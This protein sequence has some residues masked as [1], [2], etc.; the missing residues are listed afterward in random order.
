MGF[1]PPHLPLSFKPEDDFDDLVWESRKP[2]VPRDRRV[3]SNL[4]RLRRQGEDIRIQIEQHR[5]DREKRIS[6]LSIGR[7]KEE[8]KWWY[9]FAELISKKHGGLFMNVI[10]P[11]IVVLSILAVGVVT[12]I[13]K[14]EKPNISYEVQ[15][16]EKDH[17]VIT[18]SP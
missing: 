18:R 4:E 16:V 17:P 3:P 2:R 9:G 1:S 15:K 12:F 10:L 5:K 14:K 6:M 7:E 13:P 8:K 11:I